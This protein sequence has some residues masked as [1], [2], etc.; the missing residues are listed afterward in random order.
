M[1]YSVMPGC[2]VGYTDAFATTLVMGD[3]DVSAEAALEKGQPVTAPAVGSGGVAVHG[4]TNNACAGRPANSFFKFRRVPTRPIARA[5]AP[6]LALWGLLTEEFDIAP[7]FGA[8]EI[9]IRSPGFRL[10]LRG[11]REQDKRGEDQSSLFGSHRGWHVILRPTKRPPRR[12]NVRGPGAE[13]LSFDAAR[14]IQNRRLDAPSALLTKGVRYV[15]QT[16]P[17]V[18][19]GAHGCRPLYVGSCLQTE[20]RH[21]TLAS[22][23]R[24]RRRGV[25]AR[26]AVASGG[27]R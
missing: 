11:Q 9:E 27:R 20:F 10:R 18:E 21:G 19:R 13:G 6:S 4:R 7:D 23:R 24:G 15:E 26:A 25:E 17:D 2:S 16:R 3:D 5:D 14:R 8:G 22:E 12:R 1:S